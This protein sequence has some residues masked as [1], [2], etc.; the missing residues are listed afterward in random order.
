MA[1]AVQFEDRRFYSLETRQPIGGFNTATDFY[2]IVEF[3]VPPMVLLGGSL[4]TLLALFAHLRF[5][6]QLS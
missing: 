4:S 2:K 5:S 3:R 1:I 6:R